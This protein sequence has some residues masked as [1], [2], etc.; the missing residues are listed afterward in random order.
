[1]VKKAAFTRHG[2]ASGILSLRLAALAAA[3]GSSRRCCVADS[4][5]AMREWRGGCPGGVH[6]D[7][8]PVGAT[9]SPLANAQPFLLAPSTAKP[10]AMARLAW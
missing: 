6:L 7:R 5:S 4:L 2:L 1:M 9:L 10:M 8:R 3:S